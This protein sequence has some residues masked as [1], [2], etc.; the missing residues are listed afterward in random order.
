MFGSLRI[1]L[2]CGL[3]RAFGR[4]D[5]V[6]YVT[7]YFSRLRD[8]LCDRYTATATWPLP[9]GH[10]HTA[11]AIRP[12][13][14]GHRYTVTATWPPPHGHRHMVTATRP[15]PHGHRHTATATWPPLYGHRHTVTAT[16]PSHPWPGYVPGHVPGYM[17]G[18]VINYVPGCDGTFD[19]GNLL[20]PLALGL[21]GGPWPFGT[22][23][24]SFPL[25]YGHFFL[26]ANT[27]C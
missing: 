15:P 8:R 4:G 1:F 18:Y 25:A 21:L 19:H 26:V 2:S 9:Y 16:R 22:Y 7:G 24:H 5:L 11:T 27:L 3:G 17:P 20:R 10:R 23:G 14:H 6:L 12:P 13:P